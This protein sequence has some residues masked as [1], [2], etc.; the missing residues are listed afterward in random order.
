M[1][2]ARISHDDK[3]AIINFCTDQGYNHVTKAI[4][5]IQLDCLDPYSVRVSQVN[6]H[7]LN[8]DKNIYEDFKLIVQ[9]NDFLLDVFKAVQ[10]IK[11]ADDRL[12]TVLKQKFEM[13]AI[14]SITDIEVLNIK[15]Q[16]NDVPGVNYNTYVNPLK[17][18]YELIRIFN[19]K[20][21]FTSMRIDKR[22]LPKGLYCYEVK[23]DDRYGMMELLAKNIHVNFWGTIITCSPIQLNNGYRMIC[24][25]K[26]VQDIPYKVMTI[27]D[28]MKFLNKSY[29]R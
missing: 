7:F 28:F 17:I 4:N 22:Q 19:K 2:K 6:L 16:L 14:K 8:C 10:I 3:K 24:E 13:N 12:F 5:R 27:T 25:S 15:Y 23:H 11:N 20:A 29:E 9:E 18:N 1:L 26:D 21:L